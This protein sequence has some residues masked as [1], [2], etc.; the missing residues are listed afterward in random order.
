MSGKKLKVDAEMSETVGS[1]QGRSSQ[2]TQKFLKGTAVFLKIQVCFVLFFLISIIVTGI[3]RR[4]YIVV[5]FCKK[6]LP[7]KS[8]V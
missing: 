5:L 7:L 4:D 2:A 1:L 8:Y 3:K 6:F